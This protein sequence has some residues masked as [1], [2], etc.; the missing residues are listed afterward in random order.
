MLF[1]FEGGDAKGS[2]IGRRAQRP[3]RNI[4]LNKVSQVLR[5]SAS[6]NL[7]IIIIITTY[8]YNALNDALSA[9]RIHNKLKQYSLNT[10]T[11]K[12]DSPSVRTILPIY[13]H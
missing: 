9:S 10:Y 5:G 11:Y 12:I 4:E 1:S 7:I 6:D 13:N 2:I 8:I 3:R